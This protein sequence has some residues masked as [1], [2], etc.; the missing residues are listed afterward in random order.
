M[1]PP[2]DR[3]IGRFCPQ[4]EH[5]VA[6]WFRSQREQ[7][8]PPPGA[9]WGIFLIWRPHPSQT[10]ST[11][12][13]APASTSRWQSSCTVTGTSARAPS[14]RR[15]RCS[16]AS[17]RSRRVRRIGATSNTIR[18]IDAGGMSVAVAWTIRIRAIS[19][20]A[21]SASTVSSPIAGV[22]ARAVGGCSP[23]PA[24]GRRSPHSVRSRRPSSAQRPPGG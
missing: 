10:G 22:T 1:S 2:M 6:R 16:K 20:A 13:G 15:G 3:W 9:L 4:R 23:G 5:A 17:C 14:S 8:R 21:S 11:T 7:C 19:P 12:R 18:A 24:E